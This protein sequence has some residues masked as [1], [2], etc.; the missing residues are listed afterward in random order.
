MFAELSRETGRILSL[1]KPGPTIEQRNEILEAL[2]KA[3]TWEDLPQSI[4]DLLT[5]LKNGENEIEP[6]NA[7]SESRASQIS[8]VERRIIKDSIHCKQCTENND[9][10]KVPVHPN[11][12]CDVITDSVEQGV[13][14]PS[15][16][17]F[18]PLNLDNIAMELVGEGE[19][20]A[21]IQL[22][23]ET[24]AV[25][26]VENV[27]FADLARWLE[28]IEPYLQ[29]GSQ[30][31]SIVVDDDT[32]EA[33]QQVEETIDVITEDIENLPDALRN[34]KL[35]FALAKSVVF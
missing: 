7:K 12:Q 25:L 27:R 3:E 17:F 30:Y 26:D 34:R 1:S 2:T 32:D 28:Q 9:P 19:L 21:T 16:R 24:A 4:V 23:P 6:R 14:D 15:S 33:V 29:Q 11:C 22:N 20:P 31:L 10:A 18:N 35:W 5:K 13:A 8:K